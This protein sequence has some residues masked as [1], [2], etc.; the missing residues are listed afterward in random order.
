LPKKLQKFI[1]TLLGT[2]NAALIAVA[3]A[4]LFYN[5]S[6][7]DTLYVSDKNMSILPK[8]V[9]ADFG[10]DKTALAVSSEK[11]LTSRAG[12]KLFGVIP[13]KEVTVENL[14]SPEVVPLG[15][16]FGIKM[17]TD[18]VLVVDTNGF[19]TKGGYCSPAS[20]AGIKPGDIIKSINGVA[21]FSNVDVAA[22]IADAEDGAEIIYLR[23]DEENKTVLTPEKSSKDGKLKAG[24]WVKDSSAGIGTLTFADPITGIAAGLG[25]P[26][27]DTQTGEIMPLHSGQSCEVSITRYKKGAPGVPGELTGSFSQDTEIG[28]L[29][30]NRQNGVYT[31]IKTDEISE[32]S[33]RAGTEAIPLAFRQEIKKGS[34]VIYSTIDG[35]TPESYA[36]EIEDINLND[37]GDSKDMIIRI[38]DE[39]LIDSTGGIIQGM[40]GSPIIQ[41]GKI[42]GAVTHVFVNNPQKGYAI[43]ADTMYAE[44]MNI[45]EDITN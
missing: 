15:T 25:H 11:P 29:L 20:D 9:S 18:G 45:Y 19:P 10:G 27:C 7:P 35:D 8:Y 13:I 2:A 40:S 38:K 32:M 4:I 28:E 1:K 21:V 12:I 36:I 41:N 34:A 30:G 31:E 16:P 24:M 6:L 14:G 42:I 33:D 3:V 44:Q 43:F 26:V 5:F 39:R 22:V 37:R 17:L 23:N